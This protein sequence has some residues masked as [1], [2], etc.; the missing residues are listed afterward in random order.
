MNKYKIPGFSNYY[1]THSCEL[2]DKEKII[3]KGDYLVLIKDDCE[4]YRSVSVIR[5]HAEMFIGSIDLPIT[6]SFNKSSGYSI[7]TYDLSNVK[8][9]FVS[10]DE[11][12]IKNMVFKRIRNFDKRYYIS[13][14]GLI[15]NNELKRF[16]NHTFDNQGYSK[17]EL[18]DTIGTPQNVK[19][20]RMVYSAFSNVDL[21]PN[22][23]VHHK[24]RC[25]HNDDISNLELVSHS[26][27]TQLEYLEGYRHGWDKSTI[28]LVMNL[29]QVNTPMWEIAEAVGVDSSKDINKVQKLCSRIKKGRW[30]ELANGRNFDKFVPY[31]NANP[32]KHS[33]KVFKSIA[34]MIIKGLKDAEISKETGIKVSIINKFR[35]K[36]I[37]ERIWTKYT[38]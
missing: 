7:S 27:N 31:S 17:I 29:M 5:L 32:R 16:M 21:T 37:R 9:K 8:I 12:E 3:C 18:I 30:R 11:I 10:D 19:V 26:L 1:I 20:C 35:N 36:K 13:N 14:N 15:Y 28:L 22:Q 33:D 23:V 24:D 38:W 6:L 4:I 34:S 2:W 25:K